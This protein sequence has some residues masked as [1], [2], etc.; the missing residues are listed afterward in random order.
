MSVEAKLVT[1]TPEMALSLLARNRKNRS[2]TNARVMQYAADMKKGAWQI[3]GEAIKVS[4]DGRVL[5]GQ[6]RLMAILE[7]DTKIETLLITGLDPTVQ[8]T[9]DQGR[10]RSFADVLKLRGEKHYTTLSSAVRMVCLYERDGVPF[11]LWGGAS[12]SVMEMSKTLE[13]NADIRDSVRFA[14]SHPRGWVANTTVGGLHY[15]L[16]IA[17]D[18]D[19]H[20]FMT[21]LLTG[22]DLSCDNPIYVLRERLIKEHQTIGRSLSSETKIAFVVK[23]WNAWRRGE[24]IARLVWQPGG[25]SPD[26]FPGIDGLAERY[27]EPEAVAA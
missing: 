21:R 17:S 10:N 20:A 4:A 1:I 8:E 2:V 23:A 6:H 7:A 13:R 26:R 19:A 27:D 15:L 11:K 9:M 22:E 14:V 18:V 12:P 24:N 3:N 16:S 5:D 25:A